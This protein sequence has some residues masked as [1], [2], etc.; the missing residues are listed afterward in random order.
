V[1]NVKKFRKEKNMSQ[2]ELA[3]RTFKD[4]QIIERFRKCKNKSFNPLSKINRQSHE[5]FFSDLLKFRLI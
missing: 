5:Y 3:R 1:E 4:R 2:S